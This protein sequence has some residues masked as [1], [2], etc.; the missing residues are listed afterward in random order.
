[1]KP[2]KNLIFAVLLTSV[3][4]IS[5]FAGDQ[6]TPGIVSNPTPTP[7]PEQAI[8]ASDRET[9]SYDNTGSCITKTS[10]YLIF[11]ALTAL[12]SVY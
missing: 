10:D 4:A 11:E 6:G 2:V 9:V 3:L 7:S 12:L 8:A 1:M 5:S